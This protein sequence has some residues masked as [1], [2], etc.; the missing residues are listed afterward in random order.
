M[1]LELGRLVPSAGDAPFSDLGMVRLLYNT[2]RQE[3]D[4]FYRE[5]LGR[6]ANMIRNWVTI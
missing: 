6:L 3:L 5:N 4:E 1:A 2:D